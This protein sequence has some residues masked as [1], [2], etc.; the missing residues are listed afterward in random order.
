[1]LAAKVVRT[2]MERARMAAGKRAGSRVSD[3]QCAEIRAS[4]E[5]LRVFAERFRISISHAS[6]IRRGTVRRP[7]CAPGSSIF[8]LA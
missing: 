8:N 7:L 5:P 3:A 6:D 1:M 4:T 2:P